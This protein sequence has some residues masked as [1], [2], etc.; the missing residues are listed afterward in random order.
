MPPSLIDSSDSTTTIQVGEHFYIEDFEVEVLQ[1]K[2]QLADKVWYFEVGFTPK[3]GS[4]Q[5]QKG[6]LRVGLPESGLAREIKIRDHLGKYQMVS[7]LVA[8]QQHE[9]IV[10]TTSSLD[11]E[12]FE[13]E[14][15]SDGEESQKIAA[16]D[17]DK[18]SS[19][20]ELVV[21]ADTESVPKSLQK[22]EEVQI[23]ET[24]IEATKLLRSGKEEHS[25]EKILEPTNVI[26]K[27]ESEENET[28]T[29]AEA[30][31]IRASLMQ[32]EET[33]RVNVSNEETN[34]T[35]A[36]SADEREESAGKIQR[37]PS[38]LYGS[39]SESD[40]YDSCEQEISATPS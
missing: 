8:Q 38:P 39:D 2:G 36:N 27:T 13:E 20:R 23:K 11:A 28:S 19:Q 30:D 34:S 17:A 4:S 32:G 22:I 12:A 26:D 15:I 29:I 7:P 40:P 14:S 16:V 35:V 31:S 21:E 6:L 18:A 3:G 33:L 5:S 37:T 9:A 1:Y 24:Q 25:G 10:Q